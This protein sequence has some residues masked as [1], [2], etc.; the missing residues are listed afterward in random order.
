MYFVRNLLIRMQNRIH[1]LLSAMGPVVLL[2]SV[3]YFFTTLIFIFLY[4]PLNAF[5][6]IVVVPFFLAVILPV[7][8]TTATDFLVEEYRML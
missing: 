6:L 8:E 2:S 7:E 4:F 5:T 1:S 3:S